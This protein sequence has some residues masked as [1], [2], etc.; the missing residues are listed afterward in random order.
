MK[1]KIVMTFAHEENQTKTTSPISES[2]AWL[3]Y[4]I[5]HFNILDV[6]IDK[7]ER[8]GKLNEMRNEKKKLKGHNRM[9][10]SFFFK[11]R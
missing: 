3:E 8:Y 6:I 5:E 1:A 10:V 2:D 7:F 9:S 11:Y 4:H